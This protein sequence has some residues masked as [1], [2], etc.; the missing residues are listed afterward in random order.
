MKL[1][2]NIETT[3]HIISSEKGNFILNQDAIPVPKSVYNHFVI[4]HTNSDITNKW[5]SD[6]TSS[7][8]YDIL[9]EK[10]KKRIIKNK[11]LGV[12]DDVYESEKEIQNS[13]VETE[14]VEEEED[15]LRIGE[16][17]I[18]LEQEKEL[19][20]ISRLR[21]I[22]ISSFAL[23]GD[24]NWYICP[25]YAGVDGL[26]PIMHKKISGNKGYQLYVMK[27]PIVSFDQSTFSD[28]N[29]REWNCNSMF[30]LSR[31]FEK[32]MSYG[33]TAESVVIHKREDENTKL[34]RNCLNQVETAQ[35]T[36][37]KT[38]NIL[39][40]NVLLSVG[41]QSYIENKENI[42]K[43]KKN[44]H[45]DDEINEQDVKDV[46]IIE[47][48]VE[49]YKKIQDKIREMDKEGTE[50]EKIFSKLAN[51]VI[52]GKNQ[53]SDDDVKTLNFIVDSYEKVQQK[54]KEK[55]KS[56]RLEKTFNKVIEEITKQEEEEELIK[57]QELIES[58]NKKG[59]SITFDEAKDSVKTLKTKDYIN[60]FLIYEQV[61]IYIQYKQAEA[62]ANKILKSLVHRNWFWK[63]YAS[64]VRG[65][66]EL[67][68]AYIIS[69]FDFHSTVH[70]SSVLRY[71]GLDQ[72]S[73][74]PKHNPGQEMTTNDKIK[75]IKFLM[76]DYK[77]IIFNSQLSGA[78]PL[79]KYNF[80]RYYRTDCIRFWDEFELVKEVLMDLDIESEDIEEYIDDILE[81]NTKFN[82]LVN[83]IWEHLD[84]IEIPISKN[85]TTQ[86]IKKRARNKSD[87]VITT[88]LDSKGRIQ[89]KCSLGYNAKLKSRMLFILFDSFLKSGNEY[90]MTIF[91]NYRDR[92]NQRFLTEGIDPDTV[93]G[94][95]FAMGR[96]KVIQLLITDI[97][98][99]G[100]KHFGLPLNGSNYYDAKIRG[101]RGIHLHGIEDASEFI[102]VNDDIE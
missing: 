51:N 85:Q 9:N 62:K 61:Q 71:L 41:Q 43:S 28:D 100:R 3:I 33:I 29:F 53:L 78:M 57:A 18:T 30:I 64:G 38:G 80:D 31:I 26:Y 84:I 89:T 27:V 82:N 102:D 87:K 23:L 13:L 98:I 63:E 60:S 58:Y 91:K 81:S 95:T 54:L 76:K 49:S 92:L 69:Y 48:I 55:D 73:C 101:Q 50:T 11:K 94:K 35:R 36:R 90:Y 42:A 77:N 8:G 34:L 72:V 15:L 88:Y 37:I 99:F 79:N 97:W 4:I 22:N 59:K 65:I 20:L 40:D 10:K 12:F 16:E 68:A 39:V 32:N 74:T 19:Q 45:E 67:S 7:G 86:V 56:I 47:Q 44:I 96:R 93:K 75:I 66:G 6:M 83:F 24:N 25:I 70:A 14:A 52:A 5:N 1:K 17:R 21:K 46:K 2:D